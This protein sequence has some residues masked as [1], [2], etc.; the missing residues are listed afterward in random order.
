MPAPPA[1]ASSAKTSRTS[2]AST[3]SRAASPPQTPASTRSR[4]PRSKSSDDIGSSYGAHDVDPARADR[5]VDH[6]SAL[7][8]RR[9]A[10]VVPGVAVA[11]RMDHAELRVRGDGRAGRHHDSEL[12]D[13]DLGLH[14]PGRG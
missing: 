6:E 1:R 2:V 10:A 8:P 5:G 7:G 4:P 14:V 3:P 11:E 12:A 9:E 13:A